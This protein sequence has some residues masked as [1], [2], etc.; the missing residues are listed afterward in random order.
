VAPFPTLTRQ[1]TTEVPALG[2]TFSRQLTGCPTGAAFILAEGFSNTTAN[3]GATPLPFDLTAFGAP[4][5]TVNVD[6]L[7]VVMGVANS[8]GVAELSTPSSGDLTFR[9]FYWYE[10]A[11]VLNPAANALGMQVSNY[12]RPIF[13]ERSY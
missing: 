12:A 13:G 4:G 1:F 10:Q 8:A 3:G 7:V 5:C 6:P 11:L 2:S 9:G